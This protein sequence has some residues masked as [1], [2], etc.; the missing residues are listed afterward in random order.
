MVAEQLHARLAQTAL[1]AVQEGSAARLQDRDWEAFA[2]L[3]DNT[4]MLLDHEGELDKA[5][6]TYE[7]A[8]EIKRRPTWS[9]GTHRLPKR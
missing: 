1:E 7:Q 8:L 9:R 4:G 6:E 5:L 3:L 2:E